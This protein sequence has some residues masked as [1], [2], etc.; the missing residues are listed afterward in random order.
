MASALEWVK[1][2]LLLAA[3]GG[4]LVSMGLD[5]T[6]GPSEQARKMG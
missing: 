3:V 5:F 6:M 1:I 4:C 2:A